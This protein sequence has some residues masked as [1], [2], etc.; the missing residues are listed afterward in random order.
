MSGSHLHLKSDRV[1]LRRIEP[2]AT[3]RSVAARAWLDKMHKIRKPIDLGVEV[4]RVS[5]HA[6]YPQR[7]RD[8]LARRERRLAYL[9]ELAPAFGFAVL[10]GTILA[11]LVWR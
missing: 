3:P 9:R 6:D 10:V 5:M 2:G 11:L 7:L 4:S 8:K 1:T